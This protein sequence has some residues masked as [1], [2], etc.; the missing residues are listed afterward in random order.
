MIK[1]GK[2]GPNPIPLPDPSPTVGGL[3]RFAFQIRKSLAALRDRQV[4]I[5]IPPAIPKTKRPWQVTPNGDN[6][7][8]VNAGSVISWDN[9]GTTGN[10]TNEPFFG[11]N[12]TYAGG[13][14]TIGAA[15]TL[16][17]KIPYDLEEVS[18]D[19]FGNVYTFVHVVNGSL[20][21]ELSPSYATGN[22]YLPI[23]DVTV[24]DGV[25]AVTRQIIDYN[26]ILQLGFSYVDSP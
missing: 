2:Y 18:Y 20:T 21:V 15:G 9:G 22:L 7:V 16:F 11:L 4:Y 25:A 14:V 26:P 24:T 12:T 13:D 8:S 5:A 10:L 19:S 17:I 6:T 1:Q 3:G 23:A